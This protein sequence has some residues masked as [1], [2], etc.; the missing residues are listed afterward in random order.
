MASAWWAVNTTPARSLQDN[1]DRSTESWR[2]NRLF[3]YSRDRVFT[4]SLDNP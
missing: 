3:G 1:Y 4:E 2:M